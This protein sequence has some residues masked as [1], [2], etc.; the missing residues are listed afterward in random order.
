MKSGSID[1]IDFP[2]LN[3]YIHIYILLITWNPFIICNIERP[4]NIQRK[5]I[6]FIN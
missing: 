6:S 1:L 5:F 3:M 2:S 4:V